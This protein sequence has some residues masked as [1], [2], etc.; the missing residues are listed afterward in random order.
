[1]KSGEE[2]AACAARLRKSCGAAAA[3]KRGG[4]EGREESGGDTAP[5]C[6]AAAPRRVENAASSCLLRCLPWLRWISW[7]NGG[8]A[9]F[10]AAGVMA[11]ERCRHA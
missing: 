2:G 3:M 4:G 5:F 10:A 8:I 7:R 1:M 11:A 9:A 6:H